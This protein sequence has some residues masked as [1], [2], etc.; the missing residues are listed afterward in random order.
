MTAVVLTHFCI[1]T[2]YSLGALRRIKLRGNPVSLT[3]LLKECN[4][5]PGFSFP[6]ELQ[7]PDG[8][9]DVSCRACGVR[10]C[11]LSQ[12]RQCVYQAGT[13][14]GTT[15]RFYLIIILFIFCIG[16]SKASPDRRF[17]DFKRC[18]DDECSSK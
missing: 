15:A 17:S 10:V 12:S 14:T 11:T 3:V 4:L 7:E 6:S 18:A 16:F 8:C 2:V 13:M 1:Y 5:T 9:A